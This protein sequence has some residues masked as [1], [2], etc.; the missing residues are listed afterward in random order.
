M[1]G[2]KSVFVT[3]LG[4][5]VRNK[6]NHYKPMWI[7]LIYCLYIIGLFS[8]VLNWKAVVLIPPNRKFIIMK[9]CNSRISMLPVVIRSRIPWV[10][11][12]LLQNPLTT[13]ERLAQC[14]QI[15]VQSLPPSRLSSQRTVVFS[16]FLISLKKII[17]PHYNRYGTVL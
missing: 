15:K 11:W 12:L 13:T 6:L 4:K 14:S 10:Y 9:H 17:G 8:I 1:F 7:W 3:L 16:V 5:H 2:I